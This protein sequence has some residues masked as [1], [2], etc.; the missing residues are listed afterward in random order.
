LEKEELLL[1]R[2]SAACPSDIAV[3]S[4]AELLALISLL[5]TENQELHA[6]NAQLQA[7]LQE[8]E[9]QSK[10][11][12]HNSHIPPSHSASKGR[13]V[14]KNSRR[15]TG[16]KVGGQPGHSGETLQMVAHPDKTVQHPVREC[17][18]CRKDLHDQA[19]EGY[20]RRQVVDFPP[21]V[22]EIVEHQAEVKTCSCGCVNK[23]MFP[24]GVVGPVQYGP[25]IRSLGASL[26]SYQFLSYDRASELL[27]DLTG[28]RVNESTLTTI[29]DR[30][31][32][33]LASFEEQSKEELRG[34]AVI[35]N[36]ET[37]VKCE[38][39]RQ[40]WHVTSPPDVT[41]YALDA[42]RGQ[43]ALERIEILPQFTGRSIHDGWASYFHYEQ[44]QHGLCNAHHLR[45]LTWFEEEE[46]AEWATD[47]KRLLLDS[48]QL[49]DEAQ[50]QGRLRVDSEQ[51]QQIEARYDEIIAEGKKHNPL[52]ERP[53]GQRG[54][55]KKSKQRNML[56][57][58]DTHKESTLAFMHDCNVPF[59]NNLAE[60]DIRMM[61]VKQK[62][63][64]TFRTKIGA[65]R[66]ARIRGYL[67]TVKKH[68]GNVLKAIQQ[69]LEGKPFQPEWKF[70]T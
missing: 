27:E 23:G 54:K 61:K 20:E 44:C 1:L 6:Q 46:Q 66:F 68:R 15:K 22:I 57:R 49:V 58:L 70:S 52:P 65:Q 59:D 9:V 21:I 39:K 13:G 12:S 29:H 35:H 64:G 45:E 51:L 17:V 43:E 18:Q 30:L 14:V 16:R 24:D 4:K 37:G 2:T 67:S 48:K 7:R 47:M 5:I 8:L 62:V 33:N 63:S 60:R 32:Q 50:Q 28:Y 31:F 56:E 53:P 11:D 69:A 34:S 3:L 19:V 42:K 26:C 38:G 55:L 40:W 41:H 25:I 36:D 10:K